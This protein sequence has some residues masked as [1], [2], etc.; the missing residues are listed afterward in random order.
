VQFIPPERL[1]ALLTKHAGSVDWLSERDLAERLR[2]LQADHSAWRLQN[3]SGLFS[4]AGAQPK[5][6]LLFE[7]GR[8][9]VPSGQIPTTHILKPPAGHLVGFIVNEHLCLELARRLEFPTASSRVM[10]FDGQTAI[11]VERFDRV[12]LAPLYDV[13]SV[14]PYPRF[15]M[16]KIKL[17]MKVAERYRM[18][19]IRRSDWLKTADQ[20]K[21]DSESLLG[22]ITHMAEAIPE[23]A[24][25]IGAELQHA[26]ITDPIIDRL[27]TKLVARAR[28][29]ARRIAH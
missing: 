15:D 3:D 29:C 17:A 11:V 12:R 9:G 8:W 24:P 6:A 20:L 14:L 23:L 5:T 13:A 19:E 25:E 18:S 26:G 28:L 21:L 1:E 7:K 2:I 10:S 16:N 4:L 22:R 27:I